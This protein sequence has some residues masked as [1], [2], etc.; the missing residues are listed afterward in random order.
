M[1][2]GAVMAVPAHDD[3]FAFSLKYN[4]EQIEVIRC[5]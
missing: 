3:K 2:Q 5:K 4:L 1:E